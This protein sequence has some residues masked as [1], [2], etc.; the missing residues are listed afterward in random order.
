[1]LKENRK[2]RGLELGAEEEMEDRY[3]VLPDGLAGRNETRSEG[4]EDEGD[5]GVELDAVSGEDQD[6]KVEGR[7]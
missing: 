7:G 4:Q 2:R 1:L 3:V 5:S 6:R